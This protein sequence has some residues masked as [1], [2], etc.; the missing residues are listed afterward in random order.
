VVGWLGLGVDIDP[1]E[2]SRLGVGD[3]RDSELR[4]SVGEA[5]H[6]AKIRTWDDLGERAMAADA[7]G[8]FANH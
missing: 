6:V 3:H 7:K 4:V 2:P 1:G 5:A 8:S